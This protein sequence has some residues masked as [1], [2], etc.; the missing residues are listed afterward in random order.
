MAA[1]TARRSSVG[2]AANEAGAE[3]RRG[4]AALFVARGLNGSIPSELPQRMGNIRAVG[5]EADE[6]VDDVVVHL[7]RGRV[8]VQAK[9]ELKL[10]R[11]FNETAKQWVAA[12]S[13][14]GFDPDRDF[15]GVA[16]AAPSDRIKTALNVWQRRKEGAAASLTKT[17]HESVRKIEAVLLGLGA[18]GEEI[19]TISKACVLFEYR[20]EDLADY[21]SQI[22]SLLL[23]G[24]VVKK[25]QGVQ[26]W[27]I[28]KAQA[29]H[30]ASKRMTL[31][32]EGWLR[33]LVDAELDLVAD[34]RASWSSLQ[35]LRQQALQGYL[36]RLIERGRSVNLSGLGIRLPPM[37]LD[38]IDLALTVRDHESDDDRSSEELLWALRRRG[39][40][41][42]TGLPGG[43]KT[44][45]IHATA[46]QWA[47][48]PGWTIPV[49][50][51]LRKLAD[52]ESSNEVD[53][54]RTILSLA[55]ENEPN[56]TRHLIHDQLDSLMT[57]GELALFL[58]GLDEAADRS[59]DLASQI[60][61]FLD[62]VASILWCK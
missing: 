37:P 45:A 56:E 31:E 5:L 40:A 28:L 41:I 11:A 30:V 47:S 25:G 59:L 43:G 35:V 54:R 16:T 1:E 9:R 13:E 23:D 21:D 50:V 58:D 12:L 33:Y 20:A 7:D 39:R 22:G 8:L 17:E 10:G 24:T 3:Y 4:V 14:P 27:R 44:T 38:E 34:E 60:L 15:V 53:L 19:A 61:S 2:G 32:L 48:R 52:R 29:G 42:L 51:S 36:D 62:V 26:A 46:S 55:V 49:V 18:S 6:P 57:D